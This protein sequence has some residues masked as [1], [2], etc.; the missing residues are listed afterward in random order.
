M[1]LIK[2]RAQRFP[3]VNARNFDESKTRDENEVLNILRKTKYQHLPMKRLQK[4]FISDC[5][6]LDEN[7]VLVPAELTDVFNL[8]L[9]RQAVDRK[10]IISLI[11]GTIQRE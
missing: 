3:S 11:S 4:W 8:E 2:I 7:L 1:M 9:L 10:L 5:P 6:A